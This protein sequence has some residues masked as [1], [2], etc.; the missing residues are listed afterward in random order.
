MTEFVEKE[1]HT[2][3]EELYGS[4]VDEVHI[5]FLL[6]EEFYANLNFLH[7]FIEAAHRQED[8]VS[9]ERVEHSFSDEYGEADIVVVY[10]LPDG[11][12]VGLLIEDK[13]AAQLQP[14]QAERYRERGEAGKGREWDSYWTCLVAPQS[15]IKSSLGFDAA[16]PLENLRLWFS[17]ENPKRNEFKQKIITRAIS[18]KDRGGFKKVSAVMTAF[19][20]DYFDHADSF[21][22]MA[23]KDIDP[24][25]P[26]LASHDDS[27]LKFKSRYFAKGIN[28]THKSRPGFVELTFPGMEMASLDPLSG[29]L[30]E[31]M[32]IQQ[33]GKSS[34][35]RI[36]VR[37]V[38]NY[39]ALPEGYFGVAFSAVAQLLDFYILRQ[40]EIEKLIAY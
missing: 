14:R 13:I 3:S 2:D 24:P 25:P 32:S 30:K 34:V 23:G 12:R 18:K 37:P 19:R 40:T 9:V 6:E 20:K 28:I 4:T 26:H 15:Y 22:K 36:A 39:E 27:W 8:A 17:Y 16:V 29:F 21:F 7:R 35:I 10:K 1:G 11:Q 5:D 31:D 38:Q 33:T